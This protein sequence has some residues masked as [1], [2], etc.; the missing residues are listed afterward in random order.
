MFACNDPGALSSKQQSSLD[1][2]K[3]QTRMKNELYLRNHPEVSHMLSAFVREA[4]VEKPLNIHEFAAA[5]FTDLE[6]KRKIN[7]IQKEKTL[8]SRICHAANSPKDGSN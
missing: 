1:L 5:F 4:L 6:F 2:I 7:I 3:V 8:D